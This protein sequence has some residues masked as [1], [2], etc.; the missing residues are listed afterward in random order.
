MKFSL[1]ASEME[2]IWVMRVSIIIVGI[3]ATV[4]ALTIPSIYGLWYVWRS[5]CKENIKLKILHMLTEELSNLYYSKNIIKGIKWTTAL[6]MYN[7][8]P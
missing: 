2:I 4:M 7:F 1:Q 3:L 6:G 8:C 5:M